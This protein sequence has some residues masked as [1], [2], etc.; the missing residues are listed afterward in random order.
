MDKRLLN[1]IKGMKNL[2]EYM[3]NPSSISNESKMG[4]EDLSHLTS[5][6]LENLAKE[7]GSAIV[8]EYGDVIKAKFPDVDDL[9]SSISSKYGELH[10]LID[11]L[12]ETIEES[13]LQKLGV[14]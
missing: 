6:R 2:M 9:M 3:D 1:E 14:K 10:L 11:I 7:L 13:I 4:G 8:D 5:Y 12:R